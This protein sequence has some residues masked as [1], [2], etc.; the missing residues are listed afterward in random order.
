MANKQSSR[1]RSEVSKDLF[2]VPISISKKAEGWLVSLSSEMKSTGGYK[3]PRSYLIR[4]M[5]SALMKLDIDITGVK[6]EAELEL[7]I[8]SAIKKF[9]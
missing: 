6:T 2:R 5:L 4:S 8:L 3:L 1:F 9:K 7:R